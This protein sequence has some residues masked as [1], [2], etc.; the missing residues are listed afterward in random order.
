MVVLL[1]GSIPAIGCNAAF[2]RL[3][4]AGVFYI[5]G[6]IIGITFAIAAACLVFGVVIPFGTSLCASGSAGGCPIAGALYTYFLPGIRITGRI[7]INVAI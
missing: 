2:G 6:R 5:F 7:I 3:P 1:E 4:G